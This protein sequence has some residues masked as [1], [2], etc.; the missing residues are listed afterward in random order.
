MSIYKHKFI[1]FA[2]D[3]FN[4]LGIIRSLGEKGINPIV[5]LYGEKSRLVQKSKYISEY[6]RSNNIEECYKYIKEQKAKI[7]SQKEQEAEQKNKEQTE[8]LLIVVQ[9]VMKKK[10]LSQTRD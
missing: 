4:S 3:H 9:V 8:K 10:R 1:V 7:K 5:V 6:Y 2:I